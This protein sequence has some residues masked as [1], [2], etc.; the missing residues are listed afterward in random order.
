MAV[1]SGGAI[2]SDIF[3]VTNEFYAGTVVEVSSGPGAALTGTGSWINITYRGVEIVT[4]LSPG[5]SPGRSFW[6]EFFFG[7]I[8]HY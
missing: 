1:R 5:A 7:P 2:I 4:L 8:L 6:V 3:S